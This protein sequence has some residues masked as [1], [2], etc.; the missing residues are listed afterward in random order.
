[1]SAACFLDLQDQHHWHE[2]SEINQAGVWFTTIPAAKFLSL[3]QWNDLN[4][5]ILTMS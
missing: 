1:M 3:W 4:P 2:N 5:Q